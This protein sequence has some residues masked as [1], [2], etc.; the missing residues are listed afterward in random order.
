[1]LK[2]QTRLSWLVVGWR[3]IHPEGV[4]RR[5]GA[6]STVGLLLVLLETRARIWLL[7]VLI[8]AAARRLEAHVE[9]FDDA[10]V[11][12]RRENSRRRKSAAAAGNCCLHYECS[13]SDRACCQKAAFANRGWV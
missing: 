9:G 11:S 1:M 5:I 12:A 4:V 2:D 13:A 3:S 6:A 7:C 8:S 10:A